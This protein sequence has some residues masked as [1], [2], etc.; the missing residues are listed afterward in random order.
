MQHGLLLCD[1]LIF[2]SR[3]VGEATAQGLT[4][5]PVKT[6][7]DLVH[8]LVQSPPSCVIVDLN[9]DGVLVAEIVLTAA[10]LEPKPNLVG[11]GS[12]VDAATLKKARDAGFDVVWPRS[13]FVEELATALPH[14]FRPAESAS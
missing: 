6:L 13:K 14:W 5:R 1:D 3:I 8:F 4:L 11:Y 7:R 12:H 2:T 10:G 9:L